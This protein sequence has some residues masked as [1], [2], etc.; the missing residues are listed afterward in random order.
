MADRPES[1]HDFLDVGYGQ[2][3]DAGLVDRLNGG[4]DPNARDPETG[5]TALHVASRRRRA[6]AAA[7]LLDHGA[8]VDATNR[9]GKTA[10]AHAIRRGFDDLVAVLSDRGA[11]R[12]LAPADRFA[13]AVVEGRLD[14]ARRLLADDPGVARTGNPEEDRLLADVAGRNEFAPV[15]LLIAAGADLKAPGLDGGTPL[16][17]AA[18]FGQPANARALV[19]AGAPLE[20]FDSVHHSSP[21]GWAVH[22]SRF[23]GSAESRQPVYV[24]LVRLL[25]DAGAA[26]HYPG[27][28]QKD[29]YRERLR[30]D[31]TPAV[32][33]VLFS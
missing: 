31:A 11:D 30:H 21:L 10:F 26:M 22:G 3:G 2:G 1:L 5:E 8:L 24:D 9:H 13:V 18:W 27:T 6:G 20:I 33:Q 12:S 16:H 32:S 23:S 14:D 4:A 7:I 15:A 28:P 19:D 25:L 17:Q 29:D